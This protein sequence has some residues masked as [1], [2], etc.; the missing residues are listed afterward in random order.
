MKKLI[1]LIIAT[2]LFMGCGTSRKVE[3][4]KMSFGS[5]A[6]NMS[7]NVEK[8]SAIDTSRKEYQKVT[9]T[10]IEFSAPDTMPRKTAP[11]NPRASPMSVAMP[12]I[13]HIKQSVFETGVE[14][15]GKSEETQK[16]LQCKSTANVSK[17]TTVENTT[18]ATKNHG[19][20]WY[21]A[22]ASLIIASLLYIKRIP[23]LNLLKKILAGLRRVF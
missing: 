5:E 3:W 17:E 10:E 21:V 23:V 18:T 9:I 4:Q 11:E 12:T 14:Q 22:I 1:Y 15:S 20:R 7:A 8:Q 2:F 13:K 16:Q 6:V 19:W